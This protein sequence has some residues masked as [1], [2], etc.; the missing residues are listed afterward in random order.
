MASDTH[1]ISGGVWRKAKKIFARSGGVW[2][3]VK[4][5][6]VKS[7]GVWRLVYQSVLN[8]TSVNVGS[9]SSSNQSG[10]DAY[11]DFSIN[12]TATPS[13][14][15]DGS[16]TYQWT[17]TSNSGNTSA[18]I[19]GANSPTCT[20]SQRL[21]DGD[22]VISTYRCTVTS[23]DGLVSVSDYLN[24]NWYYSDLGS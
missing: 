8:P 1:I 22:S 13:P 11:S 18:S 7:G 5:S 9:D 21:Y 4:K 2:R 16:Y 6:Y 24:I 20:I 10:Y 14:S 3:T 12:R 19:S 23:S 17:R 15:D